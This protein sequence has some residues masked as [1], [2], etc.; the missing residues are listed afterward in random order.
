MFSKSRVGSDKILHLCDCM[1][2]ILQYFNTSIETRIGL[3][4]QIRYKKPSKSKQCIYVC[5]GLANVEFF[6]S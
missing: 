4:R 2:S 6:A 1:T 3:L 5:I